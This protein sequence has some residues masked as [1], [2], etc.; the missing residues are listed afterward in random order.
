[1]LREEAT[2]TNYIVY[3]LTRF[4]LEHTIYRIRG[5]HANQ[6]TTDV[7]YRRLKQWNVHYVLKALK[8]R[9]G[10]RGGGGASVRP[11]KIGKKYDFL[12]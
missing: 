3:G 9:G 1:M 6:W 11:P 7:V 5:E 2:N 4:G 12:A 8:V 10:I